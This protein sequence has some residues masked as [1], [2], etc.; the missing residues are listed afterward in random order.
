VFVLLGRLLI[1]TPLG[2]AGLA[3]ANA[4]AF[5]VEAALML[6]ILYRR[7]IL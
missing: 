5:S 7:R 4:A 3:L 1:L 6:L 2:F